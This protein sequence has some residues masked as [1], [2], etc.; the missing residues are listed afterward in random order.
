MSLGI[1]PL[2]KMMEQWFIMSPSNAGQEI[3]L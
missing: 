2:W 1:C 3:F